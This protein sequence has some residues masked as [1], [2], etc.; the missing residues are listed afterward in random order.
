MESEQKRNLNFMNMCIEA[1]S[2]ERIW[3]ILK[4]FS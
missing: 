4:P 2:I 3:P 1:A